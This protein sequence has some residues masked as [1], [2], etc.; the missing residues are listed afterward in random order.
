MGGSSSIVGRLYL[1]NR[2]H[3]IYL[4]DVKT[5]GDLAIFYIVTKR[6]IYLDDNLSNIDFHINS[7]S[8]KIVKYNKKEKVDIKFTV[9]LDHNEINNNKREVK[10]YSFHGKDPNT[11]YEGNNWIQVNRHNNTIDSIVYV[12]KHRT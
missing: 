10:K 9:T 2:D 8:E 1:N 5:Y 3:N 12:L 7:D 11:I 4:K 6:R